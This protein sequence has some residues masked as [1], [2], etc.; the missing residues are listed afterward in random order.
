[1]FI[2][3]NSLEKFYELPDYIKT[4]RDHIEPSDTRLKITIDFDFNNSCELCN[5]NDIVKVCKRLI[6]EIPEPIMNNIV[7]VWL[8]PVEYSQ[9]FYSLL[10]T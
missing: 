5:V 10:H 6:N 2:L 1:M 9:L 3:C 7:F 4:I 8:S